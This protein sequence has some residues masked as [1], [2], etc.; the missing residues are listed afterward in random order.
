MN[1][2]DSKENITKDG[3]RRFCVGGKWKLEHVL[4]AE[5][6]LGKPLPYGVVVHHV[7]ETKLD[8]QNTNLV[9]CPDN[10]YHRLIHKRM[11]ALEACGHADWLKCEYCHQYDV[12]E[13]F[14]RRPNRQGVGFHRSCHAK[15][16]AERKRAEML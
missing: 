12:P 2:C 15:Y 9:V 7:N 5:K 11:T 6:A 1:R 3:Y 10:A 8:N 16:E 13:N 14:Y 4:I